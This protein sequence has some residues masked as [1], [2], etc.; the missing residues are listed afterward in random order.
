MGNLNQEV[1]INRDTHCCSILKHR[2]FKEM[3]TKP[4]HDSGT[5]IDHVYASPILKME[6]DVNDCYYSD[7]DCMLCSIKV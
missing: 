2:G 6:I 4:T 3:A 7:H 5:I 1:S